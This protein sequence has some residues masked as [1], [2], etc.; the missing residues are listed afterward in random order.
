MAVKAMPSSACSSPEPSAAIRT[1]GDGGLPGPSEEVLPKAVDDAEGDSMGDE[2]AGDPQP[3]AA[4]DPSPS[5]P[6]DRLQDTLV[7]IVTGRAPG[8]PRVRR[9]GSLAELA[10]PVAD[11][12]WRIR[13]PAAAARRITRSMS[14]GPPGAAAP[15]PR[16]VPAEAHDLGFNFAAERG[17][18]SHPDD[19]GAAEAA[20][21]DRII[22][23]ILL[24]HARRR[25]EAARA[26][27][28][29]EPQAP[30]TPPSSAR[31]PPGLVIVYGILFAILVFVGIAAAAGIALLLALHY[32]GMPAH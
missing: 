18:R 14:S 31:R 9:L 29:V 19:G 2:G 12:R 8:V 1:D 16:R 7:E 22:E 26:L 5:A 23:Q 30:A 4:Q 6:R 15:P 32:S 25:S 20:E 13:M 21:T 27:A 24:R 10:K 3:E 28:A 17:G 11:D